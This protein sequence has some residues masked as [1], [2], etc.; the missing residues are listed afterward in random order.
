MIKK[1]EQMLQAE[2]IRD[3]NSDF[4]YSGLLRLRKSLTLSLPKPPKQRNSRIDS[5][6]QRNKYLKNKILL[7]LDQDPKKYDVD[8]IRPIYYDALKNPF[9]V[10]GL[11][12]LISDMEKADRIMKSWKNIKEHDLSGD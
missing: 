6:L 7:I 10:E 8:E 9:E 11:S 3:K 12:K 1:H 2:A 4:L 5:L